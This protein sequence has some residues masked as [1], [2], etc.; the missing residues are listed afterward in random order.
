MILLLFQ[1]AI[2]TMEENK[3][4]QWDEVYPSREDL[5]GDIRQETL[6]T[7]RVN[8]T[9]AVVFV[10]NTECDE[11]YRLAEWR[12]KQE[13]YLVLHRSQGYHK[14]GEAVFR[15]EKFYLFEKNLD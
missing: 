15:K 5:Q 13:P 9:I 10:L 7:G 1:A 12:D 14:T 11:Q 2:R 4:P 8:G 3:I 6:Y